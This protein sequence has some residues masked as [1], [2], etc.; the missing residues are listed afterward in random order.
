MTTKAR[1]TD[2][3]PT[4]DF[5]PMGH[6]RH[7]TPASRQYVGA[8]ALEALSKELTRT[9]AQSVFVIC[10]PSITQH[11]RALPR[12]LDVLGNRAVGT[13]TE[14]QQHSPLNVVE[15]VRDLLVDTAA[16]A[17]V[18]VGSGSAI[19]TS[20][21]AAILAAEGKPVE[22]LATS[23]DGSGRVVNP[24]MPAHKLPQWIVPSTP[25][26]AFAKA[27]AAIQTHPGGER[28][29]LFDP[30]MRAHGVFIDP[31]IVA[32]SPLPLVRSAAL[33]ALSMAVEGILATGDDPIAEALLVQALRQ[34]I[35]FLPQ[36]TD[37]GSDS[38]PRAHVMLGALLAGQGSDYSGAGLALSLAHALGPRSNS[39]NGVVEAVVLPH[40]LR[41]TASAVPERLPV[42]ATA[43]GLPATTSLDT[44][45][46]KLQSFLYGLEMTPQ[47]QFLGIDRAH[48]DDA[49]AHA[50]GDWAVTP[51]MPRRASPQQLREII[52]EAW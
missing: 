44:I 37:D 38:I 47:L 3:K 40:T 24:T 28:T 21:A 7:L 34:I 8:R 49:I 5:G 11:E 41:F 2:L 42:I 43:L 32:T 36:V 6:L 1:S 29:A 13:F 16:D 39:P 18:V 23:R 25:T 12:V 27:G 35:S 51:K 9:G 30:K 17:V 52:E 48:V 33:N 14:V 26:T 22:H 20:R 31:D 50:V 46:E 45:C 10:N 15:K 4:A 19:V